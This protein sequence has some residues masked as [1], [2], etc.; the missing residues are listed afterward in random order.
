MMFETKDD[1]NKDWQPGKPGPTAFLKDCLVYS[2]Y[3]PERVL[4]L[5]GCPRIE[6]DC[7]KAL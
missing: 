4:V 1:C 7:G 6:T 5:G 3:F 2:T